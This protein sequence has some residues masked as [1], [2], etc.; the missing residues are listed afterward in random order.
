MGSGGGGV[1]EESVEV[2]H[3]FSNQ[4]KRLWNL[5]FSSPIKNKIWATND[6]LWWSKTNFDGK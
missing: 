4:H 2:Y 1:E 6:K 3:I 5:Q